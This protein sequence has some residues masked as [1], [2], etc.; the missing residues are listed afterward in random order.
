MS[1]TCC[2]ICECLWRLLRLTMFSFLAT[3]SDNVESD[4]CYSVL[5]EDAMVSHFWVFMYV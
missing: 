2:D 3:I 5:Y 1:V 4:I